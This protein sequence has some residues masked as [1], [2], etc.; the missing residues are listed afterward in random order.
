MYALHDKTGKGFAELASEL[1]PDTGRLLR[2]M[3]ARSPVEIGVTGKG[4]TAY[5]AYR[6]YKECEAVA[7]E[8]AWLR[9]D[10]FIERP[11][12]PFG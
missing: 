4:P 6:T 9:G 1:C 2:E 11:I 12:G 10:L 8:L 7:R 5:A 3:G